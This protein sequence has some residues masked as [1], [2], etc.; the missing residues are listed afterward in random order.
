ME[1]K[2]INKSKSTLTQG[3]MSKTVFPSFRIFLLS[4]S[5]PRDLLHEVFRCTS[6][7][8]LFF[9]FV[10]WISFL[11]NFFSSLLCFDFSL[12]LTSFCCWNIHTC[13]LSYSEK[14][15]RKFHRWNNFWEIC[16][17]INGI[18][19]KF[20]S[21]LEKVCCLKEVNWFQSLSKACHDHLLS[22]YAIP[23]P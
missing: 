4:F 9:V 21:M 6:C 14:D 13:T 8:Y 16:T 5:F 17:N 22:F 3:T 15:D 7:A 12:M 2:E 10:V 11:S 20:I 19:L 1:S 23:I 18:F